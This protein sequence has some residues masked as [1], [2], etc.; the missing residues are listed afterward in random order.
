[1]KL[2]P[3]NICVVLWTVNVILWSIVVLFLYTNIVALRA[4]YLQLQ[5]IMQE[6]LLTQTQTAKNS[7][8]L[9]IIKEHNLKVDTSAIR[10]KADFVQS[11][12]ERLSTT[13]PSNKLVKD[14]N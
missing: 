8:Q 14:Q 12:V 3:A 6:Q 5:T 11:S 1:M 13:L 2:I 10:T 4:Q 9:A 7:N